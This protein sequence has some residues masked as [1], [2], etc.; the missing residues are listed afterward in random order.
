MPLCELIGLGARDKL[1]LR[2]SNE[3][4]QHNPC[5]L[6]ETTLANMHGPWPASNCAH[7]RRSDN[8]SESDNIRK[9]G[10]GSKTFC[11]RG[12]KNNMPK[13][14]K[15][16]SRAIPLTMSPCTCLGVVASHGRHFNSE[17]VTPTSPEAA[18]T[19]RWQTID[20]CRCK[21]KHGDA[22]ASQR[23][24]LSFATPSRN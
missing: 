18:S 7:E 4:W 13:V 9:H 19:A 17:S 5:G 20:S 1:L 15:R 12:K 22:L 3:F 16:K 11:T 6:V 23:Q 24:P 21:P 2:C 8:G 14:L 10:H